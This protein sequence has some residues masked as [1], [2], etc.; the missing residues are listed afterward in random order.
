[1]LENTRYTFVTTNNT[2]NNELIS[3]DTIYLYF[4][5]YILWSYSDTY[6]NKI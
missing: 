6:K 1:M 2:N 5:M 3:S 4:N